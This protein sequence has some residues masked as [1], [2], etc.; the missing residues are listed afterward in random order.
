MD[1]IELQ[2]KVGLVLGVANE[3]SIAWAIAQGLDR[4]GARVALAYQNERVRPHVER[5]AAT[6]HGPLVHPCDVTEDD[7]IGALFARIEREWGQLDF[8]VH[9]IAFAP[10]RELGGEFLRTSRAGFHETLDVSAYSL[11]PLARGA[12][13]LMGP[14]GGA[15]VAITFQ[16]SERVFPGYNVMGTAKAALE[17]IIRQLACELGPRAVRVC[18][19]SA[20]PLRTLAARGIP[21]FP[22]MARSHAE[23]APLKRNITHDEVAHAALFL[24]SDL[25]S[26]ITGEVLHVD[27]GYHIMGV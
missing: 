21:G 1:H 24:V 19:L 26:G 23:R 15:V 11:I 6:L 3:R 2:D 13:P 8:L 14:R 16:A 20:G 18:G 12:V 7:Q 4:S 5:L 10:A 9:S 17:Q 27:A 25:A 22:E